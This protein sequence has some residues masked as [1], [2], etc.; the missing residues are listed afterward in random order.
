MRVGLAVC[1]SFRQN[2]FKGLSNRL[3]LVSLY[4]FRS[5]NSAETHLH[6]VSNA[7]ADGGPNL[8]LDAVRRV[9]SYWLFLEKAQDLVKFV[10][11]EKILR[12][13]FY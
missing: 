1:L 3:V 6:Y 7:F 2:I 8:K 5:T 11:R 4:W 12:H 10:F 9:L 13:E